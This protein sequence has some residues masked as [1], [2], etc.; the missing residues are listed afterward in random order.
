[1]ENSPTLVVKFKG[2]FTRTIKVIIF[3][4]VQKWMEY[5]FTVMFTHDI[6]IHEKIKGAADKNGHV[7]VSVNKALNRCFQTYAFLAVE[8]EAVVF[9]GVGLLR[10][11][12]EDS[13]VRLVVRAVR[14][15]M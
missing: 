8:H 6:K 4:T 5:I 10:D 7:N 11:E 3:L 12:R 13:L 15:T 9:V 14:N 2:L 1:M